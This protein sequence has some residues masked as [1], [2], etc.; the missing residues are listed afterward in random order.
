LNDTFGKKALYVGGP[1][2][3]IGIYLMLPP[4]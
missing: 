1:I 4:G 3:A 2:L